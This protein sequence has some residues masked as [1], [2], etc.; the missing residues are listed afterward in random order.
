MGVAL[1]SGSWAIFVFTFTR[2]LEELC[3]YQHEKPRRPYSKL[4]RVVLC[5]NYTFPFFLVEKLELFLIGEICPVRPN[6]AG[7]FF[8]VTSKSKVPQTD[9]EAREPARPARSGSAPSPHQGLRGPACLGPGQGRGRSPLPA[10]T[11]PAPPPA[12][13]FREA[14]EGRGTWRL[15]FVDAMVELRGGSLR[16]SAGRGPPAAVPSSRARVTVALRRMR[17]L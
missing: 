5:Q 6:S 4:S 16:R 11:L 14:E 2:H 3:V 1:T 9:G 15:V 13:L 10:P 17:W 8:N 7:L 12:R